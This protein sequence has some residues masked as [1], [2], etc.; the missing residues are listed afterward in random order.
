[1]GNRHPQF[2]LMMVHSPF[3]G[4]HPRGRMSQWDRAEVVQPS[5][6]PQDTIVPS[7]AVEPAV[8]FGGVSLPSLALLSRGGKDSFLGQPYPDRPRRVG[9][10]SGIPRDRV[11]KSWRP[12]CQGHQVCRLAGDQRGHSGPEQEGYHRCV[13]CDQHPVRLSNSGW[14]HQVT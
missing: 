14:R 7:L 2:G 13:Q 10:T 1:M 3:I 9:I 5:H 6:S 4:G 8:A 11:A 12:G